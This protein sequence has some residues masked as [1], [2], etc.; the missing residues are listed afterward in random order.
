MSCFAVSR[1]AGRLKNK[2]GSPDSAILTEIAS[3]NVKATVSTKK[4]QHIPSVEIVQEV[5]NLFELAV[6][7]T[8][9]IILGITFS[10]NQRFLA[11][12][13]SRKEL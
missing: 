4:G 13:N 5:R 12:S 2:E 10:S 7:K 11:R 8:F 1:L 6:F 3:K 9:P